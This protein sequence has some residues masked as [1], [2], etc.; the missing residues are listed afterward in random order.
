MRS[1]KEKKGE[2]VCSGIGWMTGGD[3]FDG[4][5]GGGRGGWGGEGE[6]GRDGKC[7]EF[8]HDG[9]VKSWRE[10]PRESWVGYGIL[11]HSHHFFRGREKN[12][13]WTNF[14]QLEL[15]L[16]KHRFLN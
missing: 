11:F 7:N 1:L 6:R 14:V 15:F 9:K 8:T 5:G 4:G 13:F 2:A 12:N 3:V 16:Q 10:K